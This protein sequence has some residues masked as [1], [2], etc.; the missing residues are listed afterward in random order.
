MSSNGL[1]NNMPG[2]WKVI[3]WQAPRTGFLQKKTANGGWYVR[4]HSQNID[5]LSPKNLREK[6]Y[7]K[8]RYQLIP[9]MA[10][11]GRPSIPKSHAYAHDR[12]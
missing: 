1:I 8:D 10:N 9:A 3:D 5:Y 12:V 2:L 6:F 7:G 4:W 11:K